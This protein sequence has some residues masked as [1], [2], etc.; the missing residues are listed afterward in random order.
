MYRSSKALML[1]AAVHLSLVAAPSASFAQSRGPDPAPAAARPTGDDIVHTKNGGLLRGTIIEVL[2][3]VQ[4]RI[5]LATGEVATVPSSQV[6]RIE[7]VAAPSAP[8]PAAARPDEAPKSSVWVHVEAPDGVLIQ[9]DITNDDNWRTVCSAPCDKLLP[10][11]FYYRVTGG[12]IKSSADFTLSASP[13]TRER[14][15]VDGASK[16]ALVLGIVALSAGALAAY[17]GLLVAAAGALAG[18][19]EGDTGNNGVTG[20]GL[21][22][23]GIGVLAAAGGLSLVVSN[24]KT[25][26]AEDA[27][28][29]QVRLVPPWTQTPTWHAVAI[30]QKNLPPTMGIP[31]L[32]GRF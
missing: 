2:P 7:H 25:T 9:Q 24:S 17:I 3:E 18:D 14:L 16:S 30:E 11:A 12:G 23:M 6:D 5:Q 19:G 4:V 29:N 28:G 8:V 1:G 21:A 10:T 26:V 32:S 13:G 20:G 15:V 31:L 27:A 22:V